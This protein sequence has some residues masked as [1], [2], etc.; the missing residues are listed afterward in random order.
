[1]IDLHEKVADLNDEI[2]TYSKKAK[3][4]L[5]LMPII[6]ML[7]TFHISQVWPL[8]KRPRISAGMIIAMLMYI[9]SFVF[10]YYGHKRKVKKLK[11]EL[12]QL[13]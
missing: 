11:E 6:F 8:D 9:S 13:S 2:D 10:A 1:M 3:K 12:E 5:R 4:I 7:S